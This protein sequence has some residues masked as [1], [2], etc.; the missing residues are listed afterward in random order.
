MARLTRILGIDPGLQCTG[1]GV[2]DWDGARLAF[3]ACGSLRSAARDALPDRLSALFRG[4]E[5]VM[6]AWQPNEA[7]VEET[8][9][10]DNARATLKL[11][12]ARGIALLAPARG[13]LTVAEYAPN[14]VKKT[15]V[16]SGHAD[17]RQIRA[18][19]GYLLPKAAPETPD[20]AD[21]LAIAICHAHHRKA[22]ALRAA[23][24]A[25]PGA[26]SIAP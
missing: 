11:G 19:I 1:W 21:A 7:A 4:L 13:G 22:R 20:A 17:K 3:V 9:V 6:H 24:L 5:D 16:G 15:V 8:F 26:R 23:V 18:M 2:V 14:V 25:S 10:N 12:Q